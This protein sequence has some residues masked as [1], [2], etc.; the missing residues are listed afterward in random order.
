MSKKNTAKPKKDNQAK[1]EWREIVVKTDG[2]EIRVV[3]ADVSPIEMGTIFK[4]LFEE[5]KVKKIKRR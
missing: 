1:K 4:L 2:E 5:F 3:K